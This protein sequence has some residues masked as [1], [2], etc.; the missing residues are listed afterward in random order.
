MGHLHPT[1]IKLISTTGLLS[2]TFKENQDIYLQR[3]LFTKPNL[4][5]EY[6]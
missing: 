2:S 6:F 5:W 1:I 3:M 4:I